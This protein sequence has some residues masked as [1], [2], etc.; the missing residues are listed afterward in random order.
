MKMRKAF[1]ISLSIAM[2]FCCVPLMAFADVASGASE[3]IV[4]ETVL[5]ADSIGVAGSA[6]MDMPLEGFWSTAALR[7]AINNGLL[8]GFEEQS[9]TYIRPNDPLT[10][11]QM[12]AIVNRAFQAKEL[13]DLSGVTDVLEGAW[14]F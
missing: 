7:A 12:A 2:T 14:Y 9:G 11:A 3:I 10:R 13:S 8:K 4:G 1:A 5:A 6:I